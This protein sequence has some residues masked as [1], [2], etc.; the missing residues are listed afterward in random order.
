MN[1]IPKTFTRTVASRE[2]SWPING[3]K[4]NILLQVG[5]PINDV[6]TV[7]GNDWRSPVRVLVDEKQVFLQ[8]ACG[9]DSYQAL[10][11]ALKSLSPIAV[12]HASKSQAIIWFFDSKIEVDQLLTA[13]QQG[14]EGDALTGA[15]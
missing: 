3:G 2:F 4:I 14:A 6:E 9:L 1:P 15:P 5:E 13:A 11:L 8:N 12:H 7:T 10:S